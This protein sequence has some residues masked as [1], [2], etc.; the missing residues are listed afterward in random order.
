MTRVLK[1]GGT[2]VIACWC[3]RDEAPERGGP[4]SAQDKEDLKYLYEAR[5]D[6]LSMTKQLPVHLQSHNCRAWPEFHLP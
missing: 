6:S 3:Q 2:L 5:R 4:L 1:P